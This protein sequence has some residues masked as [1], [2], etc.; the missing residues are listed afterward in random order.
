[1]IKYIINHCRIKIIFY[2]SF[3]HCSE[4][5]EENEHDGLEDEADGEREEDADVGQRQQQQQ[6]NDDEIGDEGQ[7]AA[8]PL[9][10]RGD[11]RVVVHRDEGNGI[12]YINVNKVKKQQNNV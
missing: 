4:R 5:D 2:I 12:I 6:E 8:R 3:I 1:M 9:H 11:R 7:L 10:R